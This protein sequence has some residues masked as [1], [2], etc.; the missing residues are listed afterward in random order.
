MH[1]EPSLVS[2]HQQTAS[3]SLVRPSKNSALRRLL[4]ER[5]VG[6]GLKKMRATAS[7]TVFEILGLEEAGV[8]FV[9]RKSI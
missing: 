8:S 5:P 2:V 7:F 4:R 6:R 3:Y 9:S 1:P